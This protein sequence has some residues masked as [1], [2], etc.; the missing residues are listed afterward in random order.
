MSKKYNL[1]FPTTELP[2]LP[3]EVL[4][5]IQGPS[6]KRKE[7][8]TS[9][10]DFDPSESLFSTLDGETSAIITLNPPTKRTKMS[11]VLFSSGEEDDI[12]GQIQ[13]YQNSKTNYLQKEDPYKDPGSPLDRSTPISHYEGEETEV[14]SVSKQNNNIVSAET[15]SISVHPAASSASSTASIPAESTPPQPSDISTTSRQRSTTK[16]SSPTV[17]PRFR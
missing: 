6:A 2:D 17:N 11:E 14:L 8:N 13:P 10:S 7:K 9:E 3:E 15:A 12:I 5:D 1:L 4:P 16:L